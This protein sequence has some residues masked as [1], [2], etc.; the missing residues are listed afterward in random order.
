MRFFLELAG[1]GILCVLLIAF[2]FAVIGIVIALY[3]ALIGAFGAGV[4][5]AFKYVVLL[6]GL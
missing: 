6:F 2:A 5:A 1:Y 4:Y 3:G